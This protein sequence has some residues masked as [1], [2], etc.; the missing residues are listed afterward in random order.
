MSSRSITL[1]MPPFLF[2]LAGLFSYLFHFV[3]RTSIMLC[4][5]AH[6]VDHARKEEEVDTLQW[7]SG[8]KGKPHKSDRMRT[9]LFSSATPNWMGMVILLLDL[10]CAWV[11]GVSKRT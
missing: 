2:L 4:L 5:G 3:V 7:W 10:V 6:A 9:P 1:D 8:R 11:F